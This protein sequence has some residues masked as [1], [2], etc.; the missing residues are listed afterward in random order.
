[1]NKS[2]SE[3]YSREEE[4]SQKHFFLPFWQKSSSSFLR[5]LELKLLNNGGSFV[6][7]PVD[8]TAG[9]GTIV[10]LQNFSF[11]SE[12]LKKLL[13]LCAGSDSSNQSQTPACGAD[14]ALA[15]PASAHVCL[16]THYIRHSAV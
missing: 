2:K 7:P 3:D 8:L 16:L 4:K 15:R 13:M 10:W 9:T 6:S 12:V 1:M 5:L 14:Q 11:Q